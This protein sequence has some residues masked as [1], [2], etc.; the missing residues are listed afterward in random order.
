MRRRAIR[1][2]FSA[3]LLVLVMLPATAS[4]T[5]AAPTLRLITEPNAG[6][7]PIDAL[8]ASAKHSV[9]LVVYELV[10]PHL[11]T[12][13]AS[14]AARG[15]KVRVLL[16]RDDEESHNAAAFAYLTA[17]HVAVRWATDPGIALTH[18]KAA[19]ID[20]TTALVMTLNLVASDYA[21]TRDF[22]V[23]DEDRTDAQA[24]DRTFIA[25]WDRVP[26][27]PITAGDLVWSPGA[28]SDLVSLIDGAHHSLLI[29]NEEMDDPYITRPLE[30]AARRGVAVE[31]VMTAS[32]E[33]ESA[34]RNLSS[35][36]VTVRTYAASASLYIHAKAIVADA[37]QADQR[38]F[39]GSE[40][41]SIASL[42]HNRELGIITSAPGI[43]QGLAGTIRSDFA[44]GLPWQIA[45]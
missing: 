14:D 31:V 9:D 21:T 43:V 35:A 33:W 2:F 16:D 30:Q 11:E 25:D 18:E 8:F 40:N 23:V 10:D 39:V 45:K 36:G 19:V 34:F 37:G 26:V 5:A 29:E 1:G 38:A 28:E 20:N 22:A 6:I 42:V 27:G 44:G 7:A 15:V 41:F 12:I 24:I 17:H 32:S 13:L 4:S 3:G